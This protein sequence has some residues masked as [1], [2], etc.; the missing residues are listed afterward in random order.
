M[1]LAEEG[2]EACRNAER[3][4]AQ[5]L[6]SIRAKLAD[7]RRMER[8]LARTVADCARNRSPS[9]PILQSLDRPPD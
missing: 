5:H 1:A 7:L 4:A 9:C 3:I 8:V 6:D 2:P